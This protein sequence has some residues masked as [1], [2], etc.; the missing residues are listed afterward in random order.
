ML[1][2]D[3]QKEAL[4]MYGFS[5]VLSSETAS[6][7][8]PGGQLYHATLPLPPVSTIIGIAGAALGYPF[9][10]IWEF[11]QGNDI[12]TGVR[13]MSRNRPGKGLDLWKYHKIKTNEVL[14]DVVKREF[15]FRPVF[16][17]YYACENKEIMEKLW[18]AFKSPAWALSLGMSDDMA[19]IEKVSRIDTVNNVDGG[20]VE[21]KYSLIPGD[22][23]DNYSFD[24]EA[25][26]GT[27]IRTSLEL[28]VV[29]LL[30]VDYIF[31]P[32]GERKGCEYK[33][34][35]FLS[36]IQRL[37]NPCPVYAFG[38]ETIPLISIA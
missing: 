32:D 4:T 11:F 19:Y 36:G 38:T 6:F 30:P 14:S 20:S 16:C 8:D 25:I 12:L 28:P 2:I 34:F 27:P 18:D 9:Q 10:Q 26:S 37:K 15:L 35:T 3:D 21:L 24:W 22:H 29:K 33:P 31:G 7:R 1:F 23:S 13:D 17:L 5:V